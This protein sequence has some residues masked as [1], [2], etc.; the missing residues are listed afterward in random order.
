MAQNLLLPKFLGF[1]FLFKEGVLESV[2][3]NNIT[4]VMAQVVANQ[5]YES[6]GV[7]LN[8]TGTKVHPRVLSFSADGK[9]STHA[10]A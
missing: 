7:M 4:E 2:E 5:I 1:Q 10:I 9:F 6:T 8:I 3:G